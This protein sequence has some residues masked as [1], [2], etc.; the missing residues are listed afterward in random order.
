M[1]QL[2]SCYMFFC[3]FFLPFSFSHIQETGPYGACP[4]LP[5]DSGGLWN[6]VS[7]VHLLTWQSYPLPWR[8]LIAL[9]G[10]SKPVS[11]CDLLPKFQTYR[12]IC[13]PHLAPGC[14]LRRARTTS[15]THGLRATPKKA[16]LEI[17]TGSGFTPERRMLCRWPAPGALWRIKG[18][19]FME[20]S[21]TLKGRCG[22]I[23]PFSEPE[24][25]RESLC[26]SRKEREAPPRLD[27]GL[28]ER[29]GAVRQRRG[30][31]LCTELGLSLPGKELVLPS[32]LR[33][34]TGEFL[35]CFVL[36]TKS[37]GGWHFMGGNSKS[38]GTL[39]EDKSGSM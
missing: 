5:E 23:A 19:G 29:E 33:M 6:L 39:L 14:F 1:V 3:V 17:I 35:F 21:S 18:H 15:C 36:S 9:R 4:H 13:L 34:K 32:F 16:W 10:W 27:G 38:E 31:V 26:G 28:R 20:G 2:P 37:Y 24:G 25:P 11:S 8:Q 7:I 12:L 22:A 30:C